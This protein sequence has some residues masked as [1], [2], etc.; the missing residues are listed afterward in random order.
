MQI[1]NRL[2]VL[3]FPLLNARFRRE[4]SATT[5]A[6]SLFP[7]GSHAPCHRSTSWV[8]FIGD[9]RSRRGVR[10]TTIDT[11]PC[12]TAFDHRRTP[13][14]QPPELNAAGFSDQRH[15]SKQTTQL[16]WCLLPIRTAVGWLL[17]VVGDHTRV[18]QVVCNLDKPPLFLSF[19][20]D[21]RRRL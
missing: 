16:L 14:N 1:I 6:L 17:A 13:P 19:S 18:F 8:L 12:E 3:F 20:P 21:F 7:R 2:F 9:F 11:L 10:P 15:K 4:A 5:A